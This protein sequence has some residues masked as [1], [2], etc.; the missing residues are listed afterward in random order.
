M[1]TLLNQQGI[2]LITALILTLVSLM[3]VMAM[4]YLIGKGV[5]ISAS[6]KR[7]RTALEASYGGADISL[8]NVI[9]LVFQGLSSSKIQAKFPSAMS[10]QLSSGTSCLNEK[11]NK[12]TKEWSSSCSQTLDP[13]T[14][15]DLQFT[16]KADSTVAAPYKVYTKIVDTIYGNSDTSGIQLEGSGVAEPSSV[17]TPQHFPYI[18]TL[19]VQ[20]EKSSH[21][22]E[23]ANLSVQYA[24]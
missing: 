20:A 4:F 5:E 12:P 15:P 9:P 1:K 10:L 21:A 13:K 7:Y 16:L 11:L 2:A 8:K 17:I 19:E 6:Q 3:I 22:S 18:Y 14:S 24:Y 23:Q